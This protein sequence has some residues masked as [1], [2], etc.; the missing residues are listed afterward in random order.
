MFWLGKPPEMSCC[1]FGVATFTCYGFWTLKDHTSILKIIIAS[2]NIFRSRRPKT[3]LLLVYVWGD[4]TPFLVWYWEILWV[5][6]LKVVRA[7]AV[8]PWTAV[9]NPGCTWGFPAWGYLVE[10]GWL[11][12]CTRSFQ[13][14]L[15]KEPS[16][17]ACWQ[18]VALHCPSACQRVTVLLFP[19]TGICL[20]PN[21]VFG[22]N[23]K[24]G[25]SNPRPLFHLPWSE[26]L[27]F[28]CVAVTTE[29]RFIPRSEGNP[30]V[31][32]I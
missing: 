13:V 5:L 7:V 10:Q 29:P 27:F 26:L 8:L 21:M 31:Y 24:R 6:H 1:G 22:F 14:E 32:I 12:A 19:C 4:S 23:P 11:T 18:S 3:I 28:F 25:S 16:H 9:N 30:G 20:I 17:A 15:G 2:Q